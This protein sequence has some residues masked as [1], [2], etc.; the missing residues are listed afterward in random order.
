MASWLV[1]VWVWGEG[2]EVFFFY[3]RKEDANNTAT[4][5]PPDSNRIR[6]FGY[7]FTQ[8]TQPLHSLLALT[9]EKWLCLRMWGGRLYA[10]YACWRRCR[11]SSWRATHPLKAWSHTQKQHNREVTACTRVHSPSAQSAG[12]NPGRPTFCADEGTPTS[13]NKINLPFKF[14]S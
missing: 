5:S 13:W 4:P 2:W 9:S 1:G 7:T 8:V 14:V 12:T 3:Q 11:S 10:L 6:L